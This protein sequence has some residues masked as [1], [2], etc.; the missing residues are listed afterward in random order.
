MNS[1]IGKEVQHKVFGS[2]TIVTKENRL[3]SVQFGD[4]IKK[5]QYLDAF[6]SFLV[7]PDVEFQLQVQHDLVAKQQESDLQMNNNGF[8]CYESTILRDWRAST[9]AIQTGANK[10]NLMRPLKVQPNSIAVLTTRKPYDS[11][12]K[13]FIFAVFLVDENFKG[14]ARESGYVTTKSKWKIGLTPQEA[15][16]MLFWNYY[17]NENAPE[18]MV[19]GSGLH[20]YI[21]DNQAIQILKDII[22]IKSSPIKKKFA[23]EFMQHYCTI[24]GIDTN[25]IPLPNGALLRSD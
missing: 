21:S 16:K 6:K 9:E 8:V 18:E 22:E 20:R 5:F 15:S 25:N 10:G 24:N 1:V 14:D 13:R 11:D 19:F 12:D 23:Q 3:I 4:N 17:A 2:G 7:T